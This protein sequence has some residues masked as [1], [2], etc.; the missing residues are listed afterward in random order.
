MRPNPNRGR[1]YRRCGCRDERGRQLGASCPQLT[2][3]RQGSWAFA[4][5]MPSPDRTRKTMRRSGYETRSDARAALAR[6]LECERAGV[7][8]DDA[9]TVADYLVGWLDAKSR[10]LKP[11]TVARYRDY[12][13]NDLLPAFG[14]VRLE[15]LTHRHVDQ[16]VRTQLAAARG[17]VTVRRCIATLSSALNDAIRQRRLTHNAARYTATPLP[18]RAERPCWTVEEAAAFLRYC[19]QVDDPLTELYELLICTGMRKGEALGLHWADVDLEARLLFVRHTLVAVDNSRLVFNPPKTTGSRD[20]IALSTRAVDALRRRAR[21]HRAQALT[22][23]GYHDQGLVFCRPG[24]Q[25]LRPEHVLRHFYGLA[26][27]AGVPCIRV[28]DLRHLAAT[29]MIAS[30]VPLAM[31]SKT[32]RHSTLSTTVD[33]Y[34]HLTRQAAQDA[35]DATATALDNAERKA[36]RPPLGRRWPATTLRPQSAHMRKR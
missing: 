34:G 35:V 11:T 7:Y 10:R 13:R 8:L 12:L 16:F 2:N 23:P 26:E 20:W 28:H 30:G 19:H 27:A 31:V 17:P 14:A 18:R 15:R 6:V 24:G 9:Q 32:L 4:V 1:V 21:R 22:G 5:D 33:I 29:I 25:P 36:R 3:P